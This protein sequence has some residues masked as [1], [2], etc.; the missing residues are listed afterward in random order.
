MPITEQGQKKT[1]Q[2]VIQTPVLKIRHMT[3]EFVWQNL[4]HSN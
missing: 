1:G 4:P 2:M 3:Q